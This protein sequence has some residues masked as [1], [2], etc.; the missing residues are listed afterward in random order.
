M[1]DVN[2]KM[3]K[4]NEN[5]EKNKQKK[6]K[7]WLQAEWESFVKNLKQNNSQ[8]DWDVDF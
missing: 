2:K 6:M 3:K 4:N 1:K 8:I 7:K 5:E